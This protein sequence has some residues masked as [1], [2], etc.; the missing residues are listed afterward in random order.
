MTSVDFA[1]YALA[2][3]G[4]IRVARLALSAM[5]SSLAR[6]GRALAQLDAAPVDVTSALANANR[7][8]GPIGLVK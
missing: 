8:R 5:R 6:A 2:C 4:A 7:K 1:V 3:I